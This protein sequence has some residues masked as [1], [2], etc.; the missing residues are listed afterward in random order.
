[1]V[2]YFSYYIYK[3]LHISL[4]ILIKIKIILCFCINVLFGLFLFFIFIFFLVWVIPGMVNELTER[5]LE[6]KVAIFLGYVGW[7]AYWQSFCQDR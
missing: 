5:K 4:K 3:S 1:M 2:V 6:K 7:G